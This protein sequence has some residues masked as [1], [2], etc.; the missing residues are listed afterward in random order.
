MTNLSF[1]ERSK[2][3]QCARLLATMNKPPVALQEALF[4]ALAENREVT[5]DEAD[6]ICEQILNQVVDS[7]ET[8]VKAHDQGIDDGSLIEFGESLFRTEAAVKS[9]AGIAALTRVSNGGTA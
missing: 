3:E 4:N 2:Y 8:L 5:P 9:L 6:V 7:W 1:D